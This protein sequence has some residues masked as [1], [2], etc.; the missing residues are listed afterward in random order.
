M[1]VGRHLVRARRSLMAGGSFLMH[2]TVLAMPGC[3]NGMLLEERLA[4][5]LEG[6][7][8]VPVSRQVLDDEQE[9]A[10]R[11]MHGSPAILVYGTDPFAEPGSQPPG[12][13]QERS[14]RRDSRARCAAG[15]PQSP[16]SASSTGQAH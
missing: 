11:R 8:D 1:A 15:R 14:L 5:V 3:P 10:R 16:F 4:Q 7:R 2:L 13:R 12:E 9:A 6:R